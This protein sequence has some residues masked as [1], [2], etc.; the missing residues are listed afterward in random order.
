LQ[1]PLLDI[2][3]AA[4]K[5]SPRLVINIGADFA[6][7]WSYVPMFDIASELTERNDGLR[8]PQ[9]ASQT[10]ALTAHVNASG[11]CKGNAHAFFARMANK[12]LGGHALVGRVEARD[13][14]AIG[15][16]RPRHDR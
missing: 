13:H 7:V 3:I 4:H 2:D 5:K 15:T 16:R 10:K 6:G 12:R 14:P 11:H 8:Y 1:V 9:M